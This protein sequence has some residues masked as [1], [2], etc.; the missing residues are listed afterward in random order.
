[1]E[2][3]PWPGM[4]AKFFFTLENFLS[5]LSILYFGGFIC[6]GRMCHI[7]RRICC[8]PVLSLQAVWLLKCCASLLA[9]GRAEIQYPRGQCMMSCFH[10][11]P[12]NYYCQWHIG[13]GA[14][15]F[16][17][18]VPAPPVGPQDF[19][20][21]QALMLRGTLALPLQSQDLWEVKH[22]HLSRREWLHE[23]VPLCHCRMQQMLLLT[24]EVSLYWSQILCQNT[25]KVWL[26][27][28]HRHN[29]SPVSQCWQL[30]MEK[31]MC[32]IFVFFSCTFIWNFP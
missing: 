18:S 5:L 26:A 15:E 13:E 6:Y 19:V 2:G 8:C 21:E 24:P 4:D 17:K 1:M 30:S 11:N 12:W 10:Q 7:Y 3:E 29:F 14:N 32:F 22:C 28:I 25:G 16:L 31:N 9:A 20:A 23:P 27:K